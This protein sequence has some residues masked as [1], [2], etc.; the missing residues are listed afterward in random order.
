MKTVLLTAVAVFVGIW[1]WSKFAKTTT[2]PKTIQPN[3]TTPVDSGVFYGP[4]T[5]PVTGA[6]LPAGATPGAYPYSTQPP[7]P[8]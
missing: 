5:D 7:G 2:P 6:Y 4:N 8:N 1:A 3:M